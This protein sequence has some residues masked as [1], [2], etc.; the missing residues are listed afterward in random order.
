MRGGGPGEYTLHAREL[1][2]N[3]IEKVFTVDLEHGVEFMSRIDGVRWGRSGEIRVMVPVAIK[4]AGDR[5][6]DLDCDTQI[7]VRNSDDSGS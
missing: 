1:N 5:F 2:H 4:D 6:L 3:F 7:L